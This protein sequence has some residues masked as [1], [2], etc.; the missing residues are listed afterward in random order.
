MGPGGGGMECAHQHTGQFCK[1]I[2]YLSLPELTLEFSILVVFVHLYPTTQKKNSE[3]SV[4]IGIK[5]EK[6]SKTKPK[7]LEAVQ[8]GSAIQDIKER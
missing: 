1:D 5:L 6:Q 2:F 8:G 3:N 7:D 4:Q